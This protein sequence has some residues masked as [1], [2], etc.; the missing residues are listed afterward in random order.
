MTKSVARCQ[1]HLLLPFIVAHSVS[2][3]M[4][5]KLLDNAAQ[6]HGRYTNL[7]G[8]TFFMFDSFTTKTGNNIILQVRGTISLNFN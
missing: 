8:L 3:T 5:Y 6:S 7:Q 4:V 1:C 2:L